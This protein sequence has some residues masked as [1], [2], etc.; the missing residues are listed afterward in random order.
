[1]NPSTLFGVATPSTASVTN[2]TSVTPKMDQ[3]FATSSASVISTYT[4]AFNFL[5]DG[6]QAVFASIFGVNPTPLLLK[7]N[8]EG[9]SSGGHGNLA[10]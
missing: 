3:V 8:K 7:E 5:E 2:I 9:G 4:S 1:M 6:N 10:E